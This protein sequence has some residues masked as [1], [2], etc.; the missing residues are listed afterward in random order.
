MECEED[1]QNL[2]ALLRRSPKRPAA[3]FMRTTSLASS[4][5]TSSATSSTSVLSKSPT[6]ASASGGVGDHLNKVNNNHVIETKAAKDNKSA[7]S[8]ADDVL[9]SIPGKKSGDMP[10]RAGAGLLRT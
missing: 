3:H 4:A 5:T 9:I 10:D 6:A 7:N 1:G 8:G 2:D